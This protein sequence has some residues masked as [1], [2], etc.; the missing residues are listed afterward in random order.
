MTLKFNWILEIVEVLV[1]T[2]LHP[3]RCSGLRVINSV[4]DVND[5]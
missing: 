4:L 1:H 3:G 2:K 5:S